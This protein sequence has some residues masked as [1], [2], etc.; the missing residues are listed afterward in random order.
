MQDDRVELRDAPTYEES[1]DEEWNIVAW[2]N[3]VRV[4]DEVGAALAAPSGQVPFEY[5]KSL[6]LEDLTR[7]LSEHSLE[8]L[9][10]PTWRAIEKVKTQAAA[11]GG[12]L[13]AKFA[14]DDGA[15][16]MAFGSAAPLTC[17][18]TAP[19]SFVT[20]ISPEG[21]ASERPAP[22]V[23][24]GP[25]GEKSHIGTHARTST[26]QRDR[27]AAEFFPAACDAPRRP[28]LARTQSQ[29][30]PRVLNSLGL[31]N[32]PSKVAEFLLDI[33]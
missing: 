20:R 23:D 25:F 15:Y 28:R 26:A 31:M 2:A 14:A 19:S 17:S 16:T 18:S 5:I 10:E 13:S 30:G 9:V 1:T 7:R 11:T 24:D 8:G 27:K 33:R 4:G 3:S 32:S 6:S 21:T 12:E 22:V 29:H